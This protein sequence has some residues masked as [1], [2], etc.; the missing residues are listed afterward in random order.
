MG[1]NSFH[2]SEGMDEMRLASDK[3]CKAVRGFDGGWTRSE[4]MAGERGHPERDDAG[5]VDGISE[6]GRARC[7]S[8]GF[9]IRNYHVAGQ[10][11]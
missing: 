8:N 6:Q 4:N 10:L 1:K 9:D 7:N 3:C 2:D 5:W 11:I